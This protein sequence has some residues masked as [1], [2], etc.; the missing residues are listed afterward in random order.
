MKRTLRAVLTGMAALLVAGA[1]W[2]SPVSRIWTV[3][4]GSE[5]LEVSIER[6]RGGSSR[7]DSL[8]VAPEEMAEVVRADDE[9]VR[10]VD[11][12]DL[13][14]INAPAGFDPTA[15]GLGGA[16]L[17]TPEI[18]RPAGRLPA[19]RNKAL[20]G[21]RLKRGEVASSTAVWTGSEPLTVRVGLHGSPALAEVRATRLDGQIL[22]YVTLAASREIEVTVDLRGFLDKHGYW[23]PVTREVLSRRGEVSASLGTAGKRQAMQ[24]AVGAASFNRR[25]HYTVFSAT[26][27]L[28]YYVDAGPANTCGELSSY[29]NGSWLFASGWLCTNGVGDSTKGPWYTANGNQTDNPLFIRWPDNSTTNNE[30]HI[31]DNN[32]PTATI[33]T[34]TSTTFAGGATDVQWGVCFAAGAKI[35]TYYRDLTTDRL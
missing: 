28:Y 32:C 22:G 30:W 8:L 13:L 9:E 1:G 2:A 31:W 16:T 33:S 6:T 3:N 5:P 11:G 14:V 29:R 20:A 17:I 27:P 12:P 4:L 15:I 23:G 10:I 24:K 25:T 19:I 26:Y 18:E 7:M 35:T 34:R 21:S